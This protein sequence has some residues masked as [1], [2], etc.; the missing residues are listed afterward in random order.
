MEL[1]NGITLEKS[2]DNMNKEDRI[3]VCHQLRH[4]VDAWRNL[5]QDVKSPFIGKPI[6]PRSKEDKV[7]FGSGLY[8]WCVCLQSSWLKVFDFPCR[9][10]WRTAAFRCRLRFQSRKTPGP[11]PNLSAFHDYLS[12]DFGLSK[13]LGAHAPHEF[14]HHFPDQDSIVF[15]HADLHPSN[16][17]VS[18]G[19]NPRVVSIVDWHQS[20]WYP[21]YWEYCKARWTSR[22]GGEWEAEY[23]PMFLDQHDCYDYFDYFCLCR[24]V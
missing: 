10:H 14:R 7:Y 19:P 23:L 2:W 9:P 24:G 4:M 17:L 11:F 16:I 6:S 22:V 12:T 1:V 13:D 3:A 5:K 8:S 20:G 15:A 18:T 21:A